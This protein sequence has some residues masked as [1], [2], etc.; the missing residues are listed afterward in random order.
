MYDFFLV[1]FENS[2]NIV[3]LI[4]ILRI[5]SI[6]ISGVTV[7]VFKKFNCIVYMVLFIG[8][9]YHNPSINKIY[10]L[11]KKFHKQKACILQKL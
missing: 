11:I 8:D 7:G 2:F 3:Y 5:L 1:N 9:F 6:I 4:V 10:C